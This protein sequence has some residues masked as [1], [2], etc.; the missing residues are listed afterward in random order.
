MDKEKVK[1]ISLRL[2][3]S[4]NITQGSGLLFVPRGNYAYIF[5]AAHV[6][7]Q[8]PDNI[9]VEFWHSG[10]TEENEEFRLTINKQDFKI[11]KSYRAAEQGKFN[12]FDIAGVRIEKREWMDTVECFYL[13][14]PLADLPLIGIGF[15]RY[16]WDEKIMF[17]VHEA[18]AVIKDCSNER[19][20]FVL[21][22]QYD[23]TD[24]VAQLSG[25]SGAGLA[26]NAE[27]DYACISGIWTCS[28]GAQ[29]VGGTM[30]GVAAT[31]IIKLCEQNNWPKP[32]MRIAA[33]KSVNGQRIPVVDDDGESYDSIEI[34]QPED[35]PSN[36]NE[37]IA[38]RLDEIKNN[39][40]DLQIG[41][42]L[43]ESD[44]LINEFGDDDE[45]KN[46]IAKLCIYKASA[47]LMIS[48]SENFTRC[49][50]EKDSFPAQERSL[51]YIMLA[52]NSVRNKNIAEAKQLIEIVKA[53]GGEQ[54][55]AV[56]FETFL[57][58]LEREEKAFDQDISALTIAAHENLMTSKEWKQFFQLCANLCL[59]KYDNK[60]E[61]I[62]YLKRAFSITADKA[63]FLFI[64]NIYYGLAFAVHNSPNYIFADYAVQYYNSFLECADELLR[65]NFFKLFG[66]G[67]INTLHFIHD[68]SRVKLFADKAI[69]YADEADKPRLYFLKAH[70]LLELGEF[71]LEVINKVSDSERM[72]LVLH[73][74]Y[75]EVTRQYQEWLNALCGYECDKSIS[76][77]TDEAIETELSEVKE[78]LRAQY[79]CIMREM[80]GYLSVAQNSNHSAVIQ[81]KIDIL[82][83]LLFLKDGDLFCEVLYDCQ[84]QYPGINEFTKMEAL[85]G[86]ANGNLEATEAALDSK[87]TEGDTYSRANDVINFYFRNGKYEKIKTMY[88]FLLSNAE[89]RAFHRDHLIFNYLD[90]LSL[91]RL[92]DAE[93]V[94]EYL[95]YRN[96]L[97]VEQIQMLKDSV[98]D[99]RSLQLPE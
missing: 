29:A 13:V 70:S 92:N 30:N 23:F 11:D 75:S 81:I 14:A 50:E 98:W 54:T 51:A 8:A 89:L 47:Y 72:S 10:T 68:Y 86:E 38:S 33:L 45:Y 46:E 56:L 4:D 40:F 43:S 65:E 9:D 3:N 37:K 57:T 1:A 25:M 24:I 59:I 63:L 74:E 27:G 15:P 6:I 62:D 78:S 83:I 64:A 91:P 49:L 18:S 79:L 7:N 20:Q 76:G 77:N 26:V 60:E 41:K 87:L 53:I 61:A 19:I 55:Q 73:H 85:K 31:A 95:K 94:N 42:V 36:V 12:P 66:S 82:Y 88:R 32:L 71:D 44:R 97:S 90:F 84:K 28:Q 99:R 93:L 39:L 21:K 34:S 22:G 16:T 35:E 80:G 67:Y 5:T 2:L 58:A 96:E 48:D 52:H 69:R 17:A